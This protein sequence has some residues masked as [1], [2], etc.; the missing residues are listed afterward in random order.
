MSELLQQRRPRR[1]KR[2]PVI[3][4]VDD[5]PGILSALRRSLRDEPYE[6]LTA[7]G[8]EEA[9]GWLEELAVDLVLTDQRM[10]GMQGTELLEEVRKRYPGTARALLTAYRTPSTVRKGLES[11]TETF[12][13]KP[14][15]DEFLIETIRRMVGG[16]DPDGS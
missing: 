16:R 10:P 4:C 8:S 11:G 3:L 6:V 2:E 15:S 14:W 1:C 5:D 12:L 9:L 7:A 13:Y